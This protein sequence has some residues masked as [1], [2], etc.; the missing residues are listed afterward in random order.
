M[1]PLLFNARGELD[2]GDVSEPGPDY[3]AFRAHLRS[4]RGPAARA[5]GS[6]LASGVRG[7]AQRLHPPAPVDL[8]PMPEDGFGH[9][10]FTD[11]NNTKE[12]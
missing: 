9:G 12:D 7:L 4:E 6:G 2:P 3:L 5:I 10:L 8:E 11:F 1:S